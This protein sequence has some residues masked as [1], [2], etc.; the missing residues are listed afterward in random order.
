MGKHQ[1]KMPHS[2]L[3]VLTAITF[4]SWLSLVHGDRLAACFN[5][6]QKSIDIVC[7]AGAMVRILKAFYGFSPTDSCEYR[8]GDCTLPEYENYPCVGRESC[9]INLPTGTYGSLIQS[10][11]RYSNY[12]Q[13]EYECVPATVTNDIC[14]LPQLTAQNGYI[15]TPRYPNNYHEAQNCKTSIEVA[16]TQQIRL[17]IID[18]DLEPKGKTDCADWM[19]FNDKFHS[20]TL[21]GRRANDTYKTY[22]NFLEIELQAGSDSKSKGFWLYYEAFPPL[23]TTTTKVIGDRKKSTKQQGESTTS[24]LLAGLTDRSHNPAPMTQT[25]TTT[26]TPIPVYRDFVTQGN[27]KSSLPFAAIAGGVIGTLSVILII[28]LTLL[29]I[30]WFKERRYYQDKDQFLDHR[31][32]AFRSS[33]DFNA[34]KV[35]VDYY[36]C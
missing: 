7:G 16:P 26:A 12:F 32:P 31:N 33:G 29:V 2:N 8:E 23:P 34:C 5:S 36:H 4:I 21:C 30:K 18:M 19:Y 14:S 3:C 27:T 6:T 9:S 35:E 1:V 13:V 22:S 15:S 28:L 10:C 25:A 24:R 11:G 20:I 17:H